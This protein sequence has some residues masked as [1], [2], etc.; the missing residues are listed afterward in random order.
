MIERKRKVLGACRNILHLTARW[1]TRE[2]KVQSFIVTRVAFFLSN[3][4][5]LHL[6]TVRE[7]CNSN[8]NK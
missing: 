4:S 7:N 5:S 3:K 2:I 1:Q 6:V 8:K